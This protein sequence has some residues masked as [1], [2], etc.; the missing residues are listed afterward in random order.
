VVAQRGGEVDRPRSVEV[1]HADGEVAQAG[2]A[3][4]ES[5]RK[6]RTQAAK[7]RETASENSRNGAAMKI[8]ATRTRGLTW[9]TLVDSGDLDLRGDEQGLIRLAGKK[10]VVIVGLKPG[11]TI[12]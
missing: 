2:R 6:L 8:S 4:A 10:G 9:R 5:A 11:A 7:L 12:E 3:D 1:E